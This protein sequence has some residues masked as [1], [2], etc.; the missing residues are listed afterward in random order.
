M[1]NKFFV[2]L[3][4]L[5]VTTLWNCGD[6]QESF[7][8][9]PPRDHTTQFPVEEKAIE[10]FLAN[11]CPKITYNTNGDVTKIEVL[12]FSDPLAAGLPTF[13]SFYYNSLNYNGDGNTYNTVAEDINESN[14]AVFNIG[15][16]PRLIKKAFI[17]QGTPYA[18]WYFMVKPGAV[19]KIPYGYNNAVSAR[20]TELDG[21]LIDYKGYIID[22]TTN[23]LGE[24][25]F[26]ESNFPAELRLTSVIRGWSRILPKFGSSDTRIVNG[27]GTVNYQNY[28]SGVMIFPSGMGYYNSSTTAIPAYS[29]LVFTFN[30]YDVKRF[31][32]DQDGIMSYREDYNNDGYFYGNFN[33]DVNHALNDDSDKDGTAD[34]F[35]YDDDADGLITYREVVDKATGL[36]YLDSEYEKLSIISDDTNCSI[37]VGEK[38]SYLNKSKKR[39]VS[40]VNGVTTVKCEDN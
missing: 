2:V 19:T 26:D 6:D 36:P 10:K 40:V 5:L 35:D 32:F 3:T 24:K 37:S 20:P 7:T 31:D 9:T 27:D 30:L 33:G 17:Y 1:K 12:L 34:A 8:V 11:Y 15:S 21:V 28:G 14:P 18:Y 13:K 22:N 25:P 39:S 29:P 16:Y 38:K 23:L 4:F